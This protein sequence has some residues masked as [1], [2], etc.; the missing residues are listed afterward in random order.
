[1]NHDVRNLSILHKITLVQRAMVE[2]CNTKGL[3]DPET[4]KYSQA[5]D[6][7]I[8]QYQYLKAQ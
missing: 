8:Y 4:L 7:L 6:H 5:L 1:M 2:K 3:N